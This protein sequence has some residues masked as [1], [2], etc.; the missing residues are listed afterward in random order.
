MIQL[1]PGVSLIGMQPQMALVMLVVQ[2]VFTASHYAVTI[3]CG[4]EGKHGKSS[5]H[6]IGYALDIRTLRIGIE[7]DEAKM[8]AG[9]IG[10]CLGSEFDV[11][12]EEDHLHI[13]YDPKVGVNL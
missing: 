6:F 9:E 5:K 7:L 1:K 2:D 13:E 11:V 3:T 4:S 12:T 10:R 8:L